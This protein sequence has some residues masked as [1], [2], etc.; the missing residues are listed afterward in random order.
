[1]DR[2]LKYMM[3]YAELLKRDRRFYLCGIIENLFGIGVLPIDIKKEFPELYAYKPVLWP[4]HTA[5]WK[6]QNK[7]V[8][9]RVLR[10]IIAGKKPNIFY[11]LGICIG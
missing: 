5:W 7:A 6:K 2:Q 4:K 11:K 1:M 3:I 8:R 9:L 10:R